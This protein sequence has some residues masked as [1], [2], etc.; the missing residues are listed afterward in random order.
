MSPDQKKAF[1]MFS[2][3]I[4]FM[5]V[6][7]RLVFVLFPVYLIEKGFSATEIGAIFSIASAFL[8]VSRFLVGKL[9]DR[10]GRKNILSASLL[11]N[12]VSL[13]MFPS[14]TNVSG[15]SVVK[16]IKEATT[17]F[18]SMLSDAIMAD[19]FGKRI[20]ARVLS[21]L[22]AALPLSRA[23]AT[24][25]GF[26]VTTYFSLA[27]GFYVAAFSVFIS[28][29][30]FSMFFKET[31]KRKRE[32][33]DKLYLKTYSGSVL[34]V[35]VVAFLMSLNYTI[36]Y[37]PAFF[38]LASSLGV[39]ANALFVMFLMI[40]L[41]SSGFAYL[42]GG[43]IERMGRKNMLSLST[44][45]IGLSVMFYTLSYDVLSLFAVMSMVAVSYYVF[46]VVY[47]TVLFDATNR[48]KRGE[49]IGFVK[50]VQGAGDMLGPVLGGLITDFVSLNSAFLVAGV[51][52]IIAAAIVLNH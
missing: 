17:H 34:L 25:I 46:R 33:G 35:G 13:S 5:A 16:G 45:L 11:L 30:V 21:R 20:R 41:V 39:G 49:Q 6:A 40:Y 1:W 3:L 22:G 50:T 23:A 47:K 12:S 24:I 44:L 8:I 15:F 7:D 29:L 32:A 4:F 2:S 28:F 10:W 19:S 38:I 31:G 36:A 48:N 52:G 26:V 18:Y 9:S 42:S 27:F 43:W 51:L 14:V 37:Q